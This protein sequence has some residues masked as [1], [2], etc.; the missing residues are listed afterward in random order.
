[1]GDAAVR[2]GAGALATA[3]AV[4]IGR[5]I[6]LARHGDDEPSGSGE[7]GAAGLV[8]SQLASEFR[9]LTTS[10]LASGTVAEALERVVFTARDIVTGAD[11][12]SVTL[13]DQDGTF[14]TP[15]HTDPMA[16]RLDELQYS[17]DEG[18]CVTA[19]DPNGPA[20]AASEVLAEDDRW[21]RFGPAAADLGYHSLVSTALLV[22]A[23][24]PRLSGALN[25]YSHKPRGIPRSDWDILLLLATHA[26]LALATT[27]AVTHS[28]LQ[29]AQLRQALDSRDVIGQAK[30]ILM[31]RRGITADAAF[32]V[33]RRTSQELN[34]KLHE[35]AETI[36]T[37]HYDLD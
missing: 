6:R 5:R 15:V 10:L 11:L 18:A 22:D 30:G 19:A 12:I 25:V 29:Q 13:R 32:D 24:P 31:G 1:V 28:Q 14:H 26:S 3:V 9:E 4:L 36:A 8:S 7:T 33:L 27:R 17:Y 20:I 37:R 23:R 35:L 21:P 16:T 34:I 2:E